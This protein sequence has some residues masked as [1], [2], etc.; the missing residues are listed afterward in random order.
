[1]RLE[2]ITIKNFRKLRNCVIQ[3]RDTTFLIGQN[4]AGKSSV[5]R[6]LEFL[7]GNKNVHSDDYAKHYN[8]A[9][10]DYIKSR[11]I[12]IIGEYHNIPDEAKEWIGFKGRVIINPQPL[13]GETKNK[14]VYKKVWK[15]DASKPEVYMLEY[16]KVRAD[17]YIAATTPRELIGEDFNINFLQEYFGEKNLDT[18]LTHKSLNDK[19]K[20]L[21]PLWVVDAT[22][23]ANWIKNPGGIPGNVLSKLPRVIMI[24]AESCLSELTSQNGSFLGLLNELFN[25]VRE[26]SQNYKEA[27]KH[28]KKLAEEM[29]PTNRK[30]DFG[31][32]IN[33]L[34][35]ITY[36]LFPNSSIHV[37]ANLDDA[38]KVIKPIFNIEMESNV[39]TSVNYQGHGIIRC[40][41]F[42]LFRYIQDRLKN[43]EEFPRTSILCFEE[44]E[45]YLH[46]S[47]ANQM[48]NAL[49][50]L[51]GNGTQ[52]VATTHSPYMID[53]SGAS[54]VSLTKFSLEED[55][56]TLT[57]SFNLHEAFET[58]Q[59]DE[60][61]NLKMLLKVD[62]Y[63]ARMFFTQKCIFVEGDTEEVVIRETIKRLNDK[64]QSNIINNCELLRARGKAVFISLAKYL[65]ALGIN[66][67][68]MH[69]SDIGIERSE[70]LNP[71]IGQITTENR[72]IVVNNNIEDILGYNPPSKDKPYKAYKHI[73]ENWENSFEGLPENWKNIFIK[74]FSPYLDHRQNEGEK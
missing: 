23:V 50:N 13:E 49:Q 59:D 45:L 68:I 39:R 16:S 8:K 73:L 25:E 20:E 26:K 34:N 5:F 29:D 62:D 1:M 36:S 17:K 22:S 66:Y 52:I 40:M 30:T 60:K 7:H 72:R 24:P 46:P 61:A 70:R 18:P 42:Q 37:S 21:S 56:Y 14:I 6:A 43:G 32:L 69:D 28:L 55:Q 4:N 47:A 19:T 74:L 67:I 12:E 3:F 35:N 33:E 64:E 63:I 41:V 15:I 54:K 9:R 53:L 10:K 71:L 2:K 27:E 48:R 44:P 58:L 11:E 65:N 57:N 31:N 51:G 38:E